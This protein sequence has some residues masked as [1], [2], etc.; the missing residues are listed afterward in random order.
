V[1][2]EAPSFVAIDAKRGEERRE[3]LS[4]SGELVYVDI[5]TMHVHV[6]HFMS[7]A[8]FYVLCTWYWLLFE[9]Y[10]LCMWTTICNILWVELCALNLMFNLVQLFC[11]WLIEE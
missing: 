8:L 9:L 10:V 11:E 7:Y 1:I 6:N 4:Y 3:V 2:S 5:E